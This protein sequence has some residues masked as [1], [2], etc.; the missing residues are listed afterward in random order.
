M[1]RF[2]IAEFDSALSAESD[3]ILP[4]SGFIASVMSAVREE[5]AAL[6]PIP[7]PWKRA[8]PGLAACA[9]VLGILVAACVYGLRTGSSPAITSFVWH[10]SQTSVPHQASSA[11]LLWLV[12]S[13]LM[14][15]L[16][17]ALTHRLSSSR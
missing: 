14:T 15:M 8:L 4:S 5:A 6:P 16:G 3:S 7:F 10:I 13:T 1:N 12:L 11:G 17:I 9:A 2:I